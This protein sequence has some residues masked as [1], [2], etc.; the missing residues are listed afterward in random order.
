MQSPII[1]VRMWTYRHRF[2]ADGLPCELAYQSGFKGAASTLTVAGIEHGWDFCPLSGPEALRNHLIRAQ[3]PSGKMLEVEAGYF[4]WWNVAV[5]ARVAGAMIYESHP[6]QAIELL[7]NIR[8]MLD[9]PDSAADP[10]YDVE[11]LKANRVPIAVDIGLG[12][13]FFV[14]GKYVGLTE[15]ALFGAAVG[16]ILMIIQRI[17]KIDLLGGLAS[18]GIIMLLLSAG[19]AW[20]FQDEELIKQ[21]STIIGL[22]GAAAFLTDGAFGGRWLGQGLSRYV[23]YRDVVPARLSVAMGCVGL[24]MAGANWTVARIASTDVWLFYTSFLDIFVAIGL[25]FVAIRWSR[26]PQ[27]VPSP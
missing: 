20:Y 19:F 15:A 3:L 9:N 10:D 4:N 26:R 27:I 23:A 1:G 6:G 5:T 13:L 25:A 18:F 16:I 7:A 17:T 11:K 12:I 14:I 8:K 21:R 2:E 22:I 24:L